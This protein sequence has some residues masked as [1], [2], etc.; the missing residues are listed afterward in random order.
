[1]D[2][3][4][5]LQGDE[6]LVS[7]DLL[8]DA[9]TRTN[10]ASATA[11][12]FYVAA[13]ALGAPVKP[14]AQLTLTQSG[15]GLYEGRFRPDQAGL[16]L[17]RAQS[18]AEMVSAGIV[19]NLSSEASLG[20]VNEALLADAAKITGGTVLK[21][22]QVPQLHSVGATQFVELWPPIVVTLVLLFLIDI[23]IRRWEHVVGIAEMVR[24]R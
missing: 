5:E 17:V 6:A 8:D 2:V 4:T 9:G 18:G 23:A 13:N 20:T 3:R 24:G 19:R 10:N 21:D 15:P 14:I 11:E 16:Y 12:V 1:M 7:V 22:Q